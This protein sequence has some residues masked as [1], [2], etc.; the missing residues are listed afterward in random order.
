MDLSSEGLT[1]MR[2][3]ICDVKVPD[4]MGMSSNS[5]T[6]RMFQ[7][8]LKQSSRKFGQLTLERGFGVLGVCTTSFTITEHQNNSNYKIC[9]AT[10]TNRSQRKHRLVSLSI[11]SRRLVSTYQSN[12][13]EEEEPTVRNLARFIVVPMQKVMVEFLIDDPYN[14]KFA[15]GYKLYG[16]WMIESHNDDDNNLLV[17]ALFKKTVK[18]KKSQSH[19]VVS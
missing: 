18:K 5:E 13:T 15:N 2:A 8:G 16:M 1:L 7:V 9:T 11:A 14:K 19:C 10:Y 3:L 17:D 6:I 4:S 12:R